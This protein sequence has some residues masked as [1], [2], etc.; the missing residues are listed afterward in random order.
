VRTD[1]KIE[2][3]APGGQSGEVKF[4]DREF[5]LDVELP[6]GGFTAEWFDSKRGEVARR[7]EFKHGGGTRK[8]A[9]PAFEDDIAL[10]IIK[11]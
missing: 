11:R 8:L 6:E 7:E 9:A 2:F 3:E 10:R 5:A 1:P 4:A